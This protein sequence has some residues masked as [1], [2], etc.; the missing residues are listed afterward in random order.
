MIYFNYVLNR[1]DLMKSLRKN[2]KGGLEIQ[3]IFLFFKAL[4]EFSKIKRS[5]GVQILTTSL[6]FSQ[7]LI[8]NNLIIILVCHHSK[9]HND[10]C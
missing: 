8:N 9:N 6:I 5:R 2:L 3:I 7:K 10:S 4:S 1:K